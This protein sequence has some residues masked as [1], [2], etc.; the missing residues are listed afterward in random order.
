MMKAKPVNIL[1]L[2]S[3]SSS[4]KFAIYESGPHERRILEGHVER[5][6]QRGARLQIK[7]TASTRQMNVAAPDHVAAVRHVFNELGKIEAARNLSAI[8][9]RIVMGGPKYSTPQRV[10]PKLLKEL[11]ELSRIDP[12]HMPV[13]IRTIEAAVK[14]HAGLPQVACF[15]TAFHRTMPPVAQA[16]ALPRKLTKQLGLIR[17]GFHGLSYEYIMSELRRIAP[18][19]ARGK[20]VVAHLGNGASMAAIRGGKCVETTMGFTPA[21]GLMMGTRPGDI[22]PG[23]LVH[24]IAV[25]KYKTT[26]LNDLIYN[27]SG[28]LGVSGISSDMRDLTRARHHRREAHEALALFCYQ[29]RKTLGALAAVLDGV[30]TLV[31]TG[32][33]GENS[34][35]VRANICRGL[36]HLGLRLDHPKNAAGEGGISNRESRVKVRVIKTNEELMIARHSAKILHE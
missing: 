32:G 29:A 30:E 10:T 28:L 31:F 7:E 15:D 36:T 2:N 3:G 1:T 9:H 5:I 8:G 6:G 4:L 21:G 18:I 35:L 17:Y 16:Y 14:F 26:E 24:L 12:L 34:P 25:T 20:V 27:Q 11:R 23:A 33:I 22:D 19:S 13:E